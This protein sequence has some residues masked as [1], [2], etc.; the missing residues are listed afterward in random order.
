[1]GKARKKDKGKRLKDKGGRKRVKGNKRNILY[2][3]RFDKNE[4]GFHKAITF[5]L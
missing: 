1:L 3:A 5:V 4:K 2:A